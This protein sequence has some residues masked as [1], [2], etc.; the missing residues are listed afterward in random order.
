[1]F[2]DTGE[3]ENELNTFVE[4]FRKAGEASWDNHKLEQML[5]KLSLK[6]DYSKIILLGNVI[7]IIIIW[8]FNHHLDYM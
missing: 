2:I 3:V 1:L 5:G 7:I 8:S 6:E 4:L